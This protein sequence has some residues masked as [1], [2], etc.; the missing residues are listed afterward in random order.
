MAKFRYQAL[1]A[2]QRLLVDELEAEGVSQAIA[3]LEARGLTVLSIGYA[4]PES[5]SR[6]V[7]MPAASAT[8]E[9]STS[10]AAPPEAGIEQAALQLHMNRVIERSRAIVP[11]LHAYAQEMPSGRR[12]RQLSTV[13]RILERGDA[14]EAATALQAL[15]A[16]WIPLLS[17]ATSSRDPGRV[18]REFLT[19]SQRAD[20]LRR[21]WWQTIAYPL[22]VACIAAAVITA[23]SFL[24]IPIFYEIFVGFDLELPQFTLLVVTL[25]SWIT[26]GRILFV[27]VALLVAGFLLFQARRLVPEPIGVWFDDR[28]GTPF[29]RTTA[30]AR[31]SQFTADLLEAELNTPDVLR[32]AG[33]A[34]NSSRVRR[35]AWRL[36]KAIELRGELELQA[37]RPL[38]T[39]TVLHA[40][41]ADMATPSRIRLLREVSGS[42]AQRARA[43]LSWTRGIIEPIAIVVI[44]VIVGG[45]VIALFLPLITLIQGLSG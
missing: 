44:G 40:L 27:I 1:N 20:E 25:A 3:Q 32:I 35:G 43:R 23:L 19:E 21:Q 28:F 18:L 6:S 17:A 38:L 10:R 39:A 42:Y 13:L 2:D 36:A 29:G 14:A 45:T 24:V 8:R 22:F 11:A 33:F 41:T 31:F 30:I 34:I 16:Y 12:R 5:S 9:A 37:Y 7:E 26:S 15:P 4:T